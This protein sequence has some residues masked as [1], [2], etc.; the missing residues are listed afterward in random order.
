MK[1]ETVLLRVVD[2][3]WEGWKWMELGEF[4]QQ[5]SIKAWDKR[6]A[7]VGMVLPP[8]RREAVH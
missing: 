7:L 3:T 8:A 5:I 4:L 6:H 2:G 1:G